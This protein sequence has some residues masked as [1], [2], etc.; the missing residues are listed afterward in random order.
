MKI[1]EKF[2]LYESTNLTEKD[3]SRWLSHKYEVFKSNFSLSIKILSK[4]IMIGPS[5]TDLEKMD[6]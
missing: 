2:V 3:Y 5:L 6:G 1:F 4:I